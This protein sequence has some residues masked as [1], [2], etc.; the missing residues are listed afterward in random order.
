MLFISKEVSG[1]VWATDATNA[2][3]KLGVD[4]STVYNFGTLLV[5]FIVSIMCIIGFILAYRM[6]KNYSPKLVAKELGLEKEYETKKHL[7][8][9]AEEN[10]DKIESESLMVNIAFWVL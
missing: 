6:P 5:P 3:L 10:E 1:I 8:A 9:D 4:A 2:A 7:F